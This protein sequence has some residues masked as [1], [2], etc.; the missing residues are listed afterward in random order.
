[1]FFN[2]FTLLLM[3]LSLI[4]GFAF[5]IRVEAAHWRNRT[6]DWIDGATIEDQMKRDGWTL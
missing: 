3:I 2:G 1:M 4:A 6:E 5:G